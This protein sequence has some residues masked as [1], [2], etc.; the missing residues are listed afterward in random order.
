[1]APSSHVVLVMMFNQILMQII[2]AAARQCLHP[3]DLADG[4]L[5]WFNGRLGRSLVLPSVKVHDLRL[6]LA[7]KVVLGIIRAKFLLIVITVVYPFKLDRPL[8]LVVHMRSEVCQGAHLGI[9]KRVPQDKLFMLKKTSTFHLVMMREFIP[10][11]SD[12]CGVSLRL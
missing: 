8:M 9:H 4:L 11:R 6:L 7:H 5:K 3:C 10:L 1:M 12:G 2:L